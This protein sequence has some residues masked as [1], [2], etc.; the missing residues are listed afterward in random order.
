[1]GEQVD[2]CINRQRRGVI[3]ESKQMTR[4][5][6]L[7]RSTDMCRRAGAGAMHIERGQR[8]VVGHGA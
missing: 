2:A 8:Q 6:L 1:V 4:D 5:K 3:A 7:T